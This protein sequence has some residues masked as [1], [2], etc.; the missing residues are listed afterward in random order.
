MRGLLKAGLAVALTAAAIPAAGQIAGVGH[1]V[2]LVEDLHRGR[3]FR[4][5]NGCRDAGFIELL[6]VAL[7]ASGWF[8]SVGGMGSKVEEQDG[9]RGNC[10]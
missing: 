7:V 4:K 3:V 6:G 5:L 9:G 8:R 1:F 2:L 10:N